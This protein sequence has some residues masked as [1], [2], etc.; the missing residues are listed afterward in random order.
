[1]Y[2]ASD[3]GTGASEKILASL[4]EAMRQGPMRS[5]GED[6]LTAQ[7]EK[8][9]SEIF[10]HDVA[11]FLLTSGTAANALALAHITPPWGAI[12]AHEEAHIVTSEC[13]APEFFSNARTVGLPG[14]NGKL[15]P[16][17]VEQAIAFSK[18]G[19]PHSLQPACLSVTNLNECGVLYTPDELRALSQTTKKYRMKCHLDGA[20]FAN[21]VASLQCSPAELTWKAGIDVMSLGATKNGAIAAEAI[22]FFDKA[23]A[24]NFKYRRMRAGHLI[25]KHR[26]IAAQFL[27]WFE[28][29]HWLDLATHAN[30]MAA[31]LAKGFEA[32]DI[33]L[34]FPVQGNEVFAF[35]P[36]E[37]AQA[38]R[39][40][41]AVFHEWTS[42]S[43]NTPVLANCTLSRFVC[44]FNTPQSDID[45]FL[46]LVGSE[47]KKAA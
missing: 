14:M 28:D 36:D 32:Q 27:S 46:K 34:A 37:L 42:R 12:F 1:M 15:T 26:F 41:G 16:E 5:Y 6:A 8:N 30:S 44:A 17:T 23:L 9:V 31:K 24:E 29:N 38:L 45:A 19:D 35:L 2:L 4:N 10:E 11:V 21:A 47:N 18:Q 3:N 13:G 20:R 7:L 25:S 40:N 43:A 39:A 33:S 22:L